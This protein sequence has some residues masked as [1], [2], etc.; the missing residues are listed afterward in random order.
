MPQTVQTG[1]GEVVAPEDKRRKRRLP[2]ATGGPS[3]PEITNQTQGTSLPTSSSV[4]YDTTPDRVAH[5]EDV[6]GGTLP[7]GVVQALVS[8]GMP[9]KDMAR[10]ARQM[11]KQADLA[12]RFLLQPNKD[13]PIKDF[14]NPVTGESLTL[15]EARR[16][17]KPYEPAIIYSMLRS[18]RLET[19]ATSTSVGADGQTVVVPGYGTVTA[20][21]MAGAV[22]AMAPLVGDGLAW[23]TA[24]AMAADAAR[25]GVNP[26]TLKNNLEMIQHTPGI[27]S[28]VG[29]KETLAFALAKRAAEKKVRFASGADVLKFIFNDQ[30]QS[31]LADSVDHV[32]DAQ[33]LQREQFPDLFNLGD[34]SSPNYDPNSEEAV[35]FRDSTQ[36]TMQ[37][38]VAGL[39]G[40]QDKIVEGMLKALG[41]DETNY[42]TAGKKIAES[43][44]H[45]ASNWQASP[46]YWTVGK[47]IEGVTRIYNST[48]GVGERWAFDKNIW[49]NPGFQAPLPGA[50]G[51]VVNPNPGPNQKTVLQDAVQD[52]LNIWT[53]RATPQGTLADAGVPGWLYTVADLFVGFKLAPDV[54]VANALKERTAARLITNVGTDTWKTNVVSFLDDTHNLSG[55]GKSTIPDAIVKVLAESPDDASAYTRLTKTF[56]ATYFS[57]GLHPTLV[58]DMRRVVQAELA[59]GRPEA[60]VS[61]D[62]KA[63]L[64]NAFDVHTPGVGLVDRM[65]LLNAERTARAQE[66]W[67]AQSAEP[68]EPR[69]V[70]A[71]LNDNMTSALGVMD[72]WSHYVAQNGPAIQEI[73]HLA[74]PLARMKWAVSGTSAGNTEVGRLLGAAFNETPEISGS[75]V[76]WNIESPTLVDD[77]SNTLTRSRVFSPGRKAEIEL[78]VGELKNPTAFNRE[79]RFTQLVDDVNAEMVTGIAK[80]YGLTEQEVNDTMKALREAMPGMDR[81]NTFGMIGAKRGLSALGAEGISK[82][83]G[84]ANIDEAALKLEDV[85]QGAQVPLHDPLATTQLPNRFAV[86]DPAQIR[87]G[88]AH[89]QGFTRQFTSFLL[90]ATGREVGDRA[91]SA[92]LKLGGKTIRQVESDIFNLVVRDLFLSIW[93]PLQVLRPAYI[94]RVVGLEEQSRFLATAGLMERFD[95]SRAGAAIGD[96]ADEALRATGAIMEPGP[97]GVRIPLDIPAGASLEDIGAALP[98]G[99]RVADDGKSILVDFPRP[100]TLD[101]IRGADNTATKFASS[102]EHGPLARAMERQTTNR[103][104]PLALLDQGGQPRKVAIDAWHGDLVDHFGRDP[105]ARI[106]ME[107]MS[108]GAANVDD[109]V[110]RVMQRIYTR[111]A[112]GGGQSVEK[113]IRPFLD[114]LMGMVVTGGKNEF[115]MSTREARALSYGQHDVEAMIRRQWAVL[116]DYSG[117]GDRLVLK[118]ALDGTLTTDML[119]GL[120]QGLW[121]R[122]VHGP[123]MEMVSSRTGPFKRLREAMANAILRAPTNAISRQPYAKFW[124]D[125][126]FQALTRQ[127]ESSGRSITPEILSNLE[128]QSEQF[129]V[130]QTNRIMFDITRQSRMGEA[131]DFVFPFFQPY[132]EAFQ[133]WGRILHQNPTLVPYTARLLKAGIDSGFLR[134][135]DQTGQLEVPLAGYLAA[136]PVLSMLFNSPGWQ[137]SAPL[138]SFNLFIQSTL[139][140]PIHDVGTIPLPLPSLSPQFTWAG[141]RLINSSLGDKVNPDVRSS[142]SNWLFQYGDLTTGTNGL[143]SILPTYLRN[144]V[145]ATSPSLNQ[146]NVDRIS[147]EFLRLQAMHGQKPDVAAAQSQARTYFLYRTFTSLF[148]PASPTIQFPTFQLE[149]EWKQTL[150]KYDMDFTKA[151]KAFLGRHPDDRLVAYIMQGKTVQNEVDKTLPDGIPPVEGVDR[152]FMGK[153]AQDFIKAH[154][155]WAWSLVPSELRTG[156]FDPA[157]YFQQIGDG[158]RIYVS[159]NEFVANAEAKRGWM[160]YDHISEGWNAW[161]AKHDQQY[162]GDPGYDTRRAAY[163]ER[164]LA[165][166]QDNPSWAADYETFT[167]TSTVDPNVMREARS[168]AQDKLFS[169]TDTGQFL[170]GYFELRDGLAKQMSKHAVTAID[171]VAAQELGLTKKWNEGLDKL[172]K[173]HPDGERA[174]NY[175]FTNDLMQVESKVSRLMNNMPAPQ[176]AQI[177]DF[178]DRWEAVKDLPSSVSDPAAQQAAFNKMDAMVREAYNEFDR[179]HNPLILWWH[180][181]TPSDQRDRRISIATT[182]YEYL[183]HFDRRE[184]LGLKTTKATEGF[185]D[186][187]NVKLDQ[188]FKSKDIGHG[189]DVLNAWVDQ[190]SKRNPSIRTEVNNANTWGFAFRQQADELFHGHQSQEWWNQLFSVVGSMESVARTQQLDAGLNEKYDQQKLAKYKSI[191]TYVVDYVDWLKKD[192]PAFAREWNT[193]EKNNGYDLLLNALVPETTYPIGGS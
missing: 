86:M 62:V 80:D 157:A 12:P 76:I 92:A 173:A 8:S 70:E 190:M 136:A 167:N 66:A 51:E 124:K 26:A 111:N 14:I 150:D 50:K 112:T 58:A 42:V 156:K 127:F 17:M 134:K 18:A 10:A 102:T 161:Q 21:A 185:W 159:P 31:Q 35:I 55:V 178:W 88:I 23:S 115:G 174:Y 99:A 119:Q 108:K 114:R 166:K 125:Q 162:D 7:T 116:M 113:E 53:G 2:A 49:F 103:Y 13:T 82:E 188:V 85:L 191:R 91:A 6:T 172:F 131:L 77:V 147:D 24:L 32:T 43:I 69:R 83:F 71:F 137:V 97:A 15:D 146:G 29:V 40:N 181:Q 177:N 78:L 164:V 79:A 143:M 64:L 95:S 192:S 193:L 65:G 109:V 145:Q 153:G 20:K 52:T 140:I 160:V 41:N 46:L 16:Y 168:L 120:D 130:L 28:K 84:V 98:Q 60:E 129:A 138:S 74:N 106:T 30:G 3:L 132:A 165:L 148:F 75:H 141:Q 4:A 39:L 19:A 179:K 158:T 135:N 154:P 101:P 123:E 175:F 176:R 128:R 93:K 180:N 34:P 27:D 171:Q 149:N 94:L 144:F 118:S 152:F 89:A 182:P 105:I 133:V 90:R 61:M 63:L 107:E 36:G 37:T 104:E 72:D 81:P 183:S 189:F 121:P 117:N 59:A 45:N 38:S 67:R 33:R 48:V 186:L 1:S 122:S 68:V 139:P 56:R 22:K 11:A 25:S 142:L 151:Q 169:Q 110:Q 54:L 9:N 96:K 73:P 187:Y 163:H 87:E 44:T 5:I 155:R 57:E 47:V 126:M 100:G 170:N 184:V